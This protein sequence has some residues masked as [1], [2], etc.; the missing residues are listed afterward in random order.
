VVIE[1]VQLGDFTIQTGIDSQVKCARLIIM[2]LTLGPAIF[3][4]EMEPRAYSR[5]PV[6]SQFIVFTYA[7]Q[8]G[9]VLLD[10]SLPLRDVSVKLNSGA[11]GY[12]R[13]FGLA[14]RQ[15]NVSVLVPYILGRATGTVFEEQ[16][17]VRRSGLGDVRLRFSTILKGG[18]ALSPR[19][20]TS[21]KPRMLLGVSLTIVAPTGQYDPRRLVN[22]GSNRWA[23][24][25]EV[26]LSKPSG[27]WTLELVSGIWI[28]TDNENFFGGSR[29]EQKPLTSFGGHVIYTIRPRMWASVNATYYTGGRTT[30][31]GI[32][33]EDTQKN[34]RIG[35]TYSFPLNNRQSIKVAYASGLTTRFGGHLKT[36]GVGWVYAW[37]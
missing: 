14:G 22:P 11:M 26:G 37:F 24:K 33:N 28:F 35:A 9:D 7:Y 10:S 34:S 32:V 2:V 13:T 25:P 31:N 29:R 19:E 36:I 3:A 30:V 16:H 27:R 8:N 21:Y 15:A 5:A 18:P 12:G 23:I 17:E 6:G 1:H 20:F 4:Q